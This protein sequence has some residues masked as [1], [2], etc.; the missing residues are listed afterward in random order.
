MFVIEENLLDEWCGLWF[1]HVTID[2][3]SDMQAYVGI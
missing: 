3:Q 2:S 1:V